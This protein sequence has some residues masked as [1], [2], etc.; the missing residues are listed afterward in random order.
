MTFNLTAMPV[1][2]AIASLPNWLSFDSQGTGL[3]LAQSNSWF[4]VWITPLWI[5]A[6]GLVIGAVASLMVFG[7]LALLSLIPPLGKLA[8]HRRTG[9]STSLVLGGLIGAVLCYLWIPQA[10]EYSETLYLPLICIGLVIGFAVVYGM[11][12]RTRKEW[13]TIVGE[14]I[15]PYVLSTMGVFAVVGLLGTPWIE[16]RDDILESIGAVNWVSDGE[17][18][19]PVNDIPAASTDTNAETVFYHAGINY[20]LRNVTEVRIASTGTVYLADNSD[21]EMFSRTPRRVDAG[22]EIV[23]RPGDGVSPIPADPTRLHIH[24]QEIVPTTVTFTFKTRPKVPQAASIIKVAVG[25]FLFVTAVV[26]FRQAAPRVWALSLSTAKNEMAQPL[27]LL[28]LAIGIFGVTLFGIY[29]FHT[30]GDDIRMLKD[31]GVTLIMVLG[32]IQ[33]VWSAG[34]SVSDEIEGR[35]ALTVLSKPVSRRTFVLGKYA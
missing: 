23:F 26:A 31:S 2:G 20:Q 17:Q 21:P 35:T 33:A 5:I 19:I 12:H 1:D 7:I 10:G 30:L 29:P 18:V 14:G 28:L 34:T 22:E 3:I 32:M 16:K 4:P 24:N 25:F 6:V 8:D 27:Y 11:W 15:V 13:T 9:I